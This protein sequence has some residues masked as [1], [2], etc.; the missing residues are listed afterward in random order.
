LYKYHELRTVHLEITS[1]CNA[2]CPMCLRTVCGG[3][4]NPQLPLVELSLSDIKNIFPV[5]FVSQLNRMFMCGN[6]GDPI[7]AKD[8]LPVF[9]YFREHNSNIR[10]DMFTNGSARNEDFWREL[11]TVVDTVHFSVDGLED[12]NHLYRKGTHFPTIMKNAR[13]FMGGGG[14]AVWDFIVFRHNEHQIDE[15]QL[16]SQEMGFKSFNLKKTGRFFSNTKMEAKS[17]QVVY[18]R[19]GEVD[20]YLELPQNPDFQNSALLKEKQ[21]V[22]KYGSLENYL[23]QTPVRCKVA[24]E[25]S[26]YISAVGHAFPCCWTANQLYPWYYP[27]K[28][29]YMW[30]LLDQ[31]EEGVDGL[32]AKQNSLESI[33]NGAFFQDILTSS[34][35]KKSIKDGKPKCCAKTCGTEFDPFK[36][37]FTKT[38]TKSGASSILRNWLGMIK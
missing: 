6:Y 4:D 17:R 32:S 28:K 26:I 36:A 38:Q 35:D 11:A 21:L 25:K 12:T 3:Q 27:A 15:A 31:L 23:N 13:A 33:V 5:S 37:Q 34:W 18:D 19:Q 9:K 14:K 8:T 2:R 22:E 7:I 20:Y 10:L 30:K 16:L 24:K 1:K 29:S